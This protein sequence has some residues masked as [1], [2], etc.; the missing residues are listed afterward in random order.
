MLGLA[1][2][3]I[4]LD[5]RRSTRTELIGPDP[6]GSLAVEVKGSPRPARS[7]L[8]ELQAALPAFEDRAPKQTAMTLVFANATRRRGS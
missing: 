6:G 8:G 2:Q 1:V 4:D 5:Q 3:S 7:H